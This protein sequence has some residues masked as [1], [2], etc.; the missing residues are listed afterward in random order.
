MPIAC[1]SAATVC[2]SKRRRK[3]SPLDRVQSLMERSHPSSGRSATPADIN[4]NARPT[5]FGTGG[6]HQSECPA[7]IIG[8][9]TYAVHGDKNGRCEAAK[10]EP[11]TL[12]AFGWLDHPL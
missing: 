3:A 12:G 4:R 11:A 1:S 2:A 8:I 7:D 5:S 6:R 10:N 9:R